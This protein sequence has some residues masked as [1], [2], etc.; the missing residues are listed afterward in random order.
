MERSGTYQLKAP[1]LAPCSNKNDLTQLKDDACGPVT[2]TRQPDTSG[3]TSCQY[4]KTTPDVWA[5]NAVS[6]GE[7]KPESFKYDLFRYQLY[8]QPAGYNCHGEQV[9]T[10]PNK[11]YDAPT[12][13]VRALR[14]TMFIPVVPTKPGGERDVT[15]PMT[16]QTMGQ[17]DVTTACCV[18]VIPCNPGF[19]NLTAN[20]YPDP[21]VVCDTYNRCNLAGQNTHGRVDICSD[22]Q[23]I[24]NQQHDFEPPPPQQFMMPPSNLQSSG[25]CG[26]PPTFPPVNQLYGPAS[27]QAGMPMMGYSQGEGHPQQLHQQ[28]YATNQQAVLQQQQQAVDY[29]RGSS[30]TNP[31]CVDAIDDGM[32]LTGNKRA[33][34]SSNKTF[35]FT[36]RAT[37]AILANMEPPEKRDVRL[38][39]MYGSYGSFL[40][41]RVTPRRC[42]QGP[43]SNINTQ[44]NGFRWCYPQTENNLCYVIERNPRC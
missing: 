1:T 36:D 20:I 40:L 25:C 16:P 26:F 27:Q 9:K 30:C 7:L 4:Y 8:A 41:A 10:V 32:N 21:R 28:P 37:R 18:P 5:N 19:Q 3:L 17:P 23:Q 35:R 43:K 11:Q 24:A 12:T 22:K 44:G 31:A 38:R 34:C 6:V 2:C 42:L 13:D 14:Q 29:M 39:T 33:V 15:F